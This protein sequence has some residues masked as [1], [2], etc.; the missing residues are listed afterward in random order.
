VL[1]GQRGLSVNMM[2]NLVEGLGIPPKIF[3]AKPKVKAASKRRVFQ[4]H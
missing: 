4:V 2:R 3:L 1:S